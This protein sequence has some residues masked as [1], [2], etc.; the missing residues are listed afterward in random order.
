MKGLDMKIK[1]KRVYETPSAEDGRRLL[2]DRLWPRG[3]SKDKARVDEWLK[4]LAPSDG[5]RKW[6]GHDP[7]KWEEFQKR[8]FAE[9]DEIPDGRK[10]IHPE[11]QDGNITLLFAAK[12]LEHNN[13]VAL[14]TYL[15]NHSSN[16]KSGSRA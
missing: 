16:G 14:K 3:L 4:D 7:D 5:L 2:V 8:Y 6:F 9:L 10:R 1:V 15:G 11:G 13:A 12:D